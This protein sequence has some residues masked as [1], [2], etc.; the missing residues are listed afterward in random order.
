MLK[1]LPEY[2]ITNRD[3]AFINADCNTKIINTLVRKINKLISAVNNQQIQLNNHECRLLDLQN[4][5]TALDDPTYHEDED[6]D[7]YDDPKYREQP[8]DPYAEQRKWD[9]KLCRFWNVNKD[10]ATYGILEKVVLNWAY[11]F[12]AKGDP[13]LW[14]HCEPVKPDDDIIYKGV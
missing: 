5:V 1:K 12:K 9:G 3:G 4:R 11:K 8:A 2:E 6:S 10:S 14:D 13:Y 7:W